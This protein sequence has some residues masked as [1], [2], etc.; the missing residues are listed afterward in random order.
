MHFC[1]ISLYKYRFLLHKVHFNNYFFIMQKT[2]FTI[3]ILY[4]IIIL[5]I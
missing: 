1:V 5:P 3:F 2:F 4:I